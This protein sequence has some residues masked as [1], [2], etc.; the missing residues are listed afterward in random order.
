MNKLKLIICLFFSFLSFVKNDSAEEFLKYCDCRTDE[1]LIYIIMILEDIVKIKISDKFIKK[2]NELTKQIRNIGIDNLN[3]SDTNEFEQLI[4]SNYKFIN[5][6]NEELFNINT[7]RYLLILWAIN[8]NKYLTKDKVF[9]GGLIDYINYLPNQDILNFININ[10]EKNPELKENIEMRNNII[11]NIKNLKKPVNVYVYLNEKTDKNL[12]QYIYNYEYY[13]YL[14]KKEQSRTSSQYVREELFTLEKNELL[15]IVYEYVNEFQETKKFHNFIQ[16]IENKNFKYVSPEEYIEDEVLFNYNKICMACEYYNRRN[17]GI[18]KAL[19]SLSDYIFQINSYY[20][21]K[22][23]IE[24]FKL[25]PEL[26]QN[27][28]FEDIYKNDSHNKYDE[29]QDFLYVQPREQILKYYLNLGYLYKV[30]NYFDILDNIYYYSNKHIIILIN[31]ITNK[32]QTLQNIKSLENI[33]HL[34]KNNISCYLESKPRRQLQLILKDT[35]KYYLD[36]NKFY[37]EKTELPNLLLQKN[38]ALISYITTI[39]GLNETLKFINLTKKYTFESSPEFGDI[40]DF[41][42]AIN[43]NYL[44]KWLFLFEKYSREEKKYNNIYGG[45]KYSLSLEIDKKSKNDIIDMIIIHLNQYEQFKIPEN[46]IE[47]IQIPNNTSHH[48]ILNLSLDSLNEVVEILDCYS[49]RKNL[50]INF[51]ERNIYEVINCNDNRNKCIFFLFRLLAIFPELN[52]PL[53]FNLITTGKNKEINPLI[54]YADV[55]YTQNNLLYL[56]KNIQKYINETNIE[57]DSTDFEKENI[58]Q[59]I[60]TKIENEKLIKNN[61]I[62]YC[63]LFY[64][65]TEFLYFENYQ[66]Y[67]KRNWPKR[68]ETIINNC[69]TYFTEKYNINLTNITIEIM[70]EIISNYSEFKDPKFFFNN[71]DPLKEDE[72]KIFKKYDK[73]TLIKY[74]FVCFIF[75]YNN[76]SNHEFEYRNF[77]QMNKNELVIYVNNIMTKLEIKFDKLNEHIRKNYLNYS[78]EDINYLTLY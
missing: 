30:D 38:N 18:N 20:K 2:R 41:L 34:N 10:M 61:P 53:I 39:I 27:K 69:K 15:N 1:E 44:K 54:N 24:K 33:A 17:K 72:M 11:L 6:T 5:S 57:K 74:A 28:R 42:R 62:T 25:Y 47:L 29:V 19:R 43:I 40:T 77:Y 78:E 58:K 8:L 60:I 45:M 4:Q 36:V 67:L 63:R 31:K 68:N 23:I 55:I 71:I 32:N 3:I 73:S 66:H 26:L 13:S 70:D 49:K 50:Q 65:E 52:D 59:Y 48:L 75:N 21:R 37:V 64:N 9:V 22:Y 56:A 35:R 14:I 51:G 12:I 16:K 7:E 46:F 76:S